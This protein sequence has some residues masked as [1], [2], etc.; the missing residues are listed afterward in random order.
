MNLINNQNIE[1]TI[2]KIRDTKVMLD[3]DLSSLYEVETKYLN[4]QIKRNFERF[5]EEDFMFQLTDK[6][7]KDL[8]CQIGTTNLS[9]TR[10][11]PYVFTEQGVYMLATVINS[12]VAIDITKK[13]MRTF[14]KM[15]EFT[16]NYNDVTKKLKEIEK[17]IKIDQQNL[18]YSHHR[19]D[20]AFKLLNEILEDTQKTNNRIIGFRPKTD[21]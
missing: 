14:T 5:N 9:M 12:D 2:Y 8:R 13:I 21:S 4:R 6:E 15:R 3:S 16:L 18:N 1:T 17:T 20:D 7:L 11:L 10:T 19:I